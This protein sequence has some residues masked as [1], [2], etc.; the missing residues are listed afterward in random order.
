MET[1]IILT[2]TAIC[3]GVFK[4]FRI[5]LNKWTVPTAALGGVVLVGTMVFVMNFN[6]PYSEITREYFVT[7]PIL[8]EV[9]GKVQ[10]VEAKPGVLL[11][12]D[13]V[14][15]TI[16]PEPFQLAVDDLAAQFEVANAD[17]KRA[18]ELLRRK[19]GSQRDADNARGR[20][21]SLAAKL[22]SAKRD[23]QSTQVRAPSDGYVLQ[24][25]VRPGVMAV[26]MP[27]RPVMIFLPV[28]EMYLIGWYRQNNLQRLVVGN[29]A[30]VAFDSIPGRVFSGVVASV[31][32]GIRQGQVQPSGELIDPGLA[33][34]PGRVAVLI[35]IT[36][37]RFEDYRPLIIGGAYAQSAVYSEHAEH[38]QIIRRV[39]LRMSSW[40]NYFFP[41]H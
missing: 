4:A 23:L 5:P 31:P 10:S 19:L 32:P 6:H 17:A 30:E 3:V 14:L 1:L 13:D 41:F 36:D 11:K 39:I 12:K 7:T 25:A 34:A 24:V 16:D 38:V 35:Q 27:L 33:P 21:N 37:E 2:Y 20:A 9:R 40:L 28:E 29:E 18:E 15:F 26:P 8:P 22:A